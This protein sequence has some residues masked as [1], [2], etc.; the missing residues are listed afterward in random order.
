MK[1]GTS[2]AHMGLEADHRVGADVDELV[3][4]GQ[5][6]MMAQSPT[7]TWPA[8]VA[9][10]ASMQWLP[11]LHV[12]RQVHVGH[13]PVVVAHARDAAVLHLCRC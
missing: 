5:P 4:A 6:P 11:S 8:S 7:C 3:H 13:D 1:G 9:L 12:V 10:L 2:C